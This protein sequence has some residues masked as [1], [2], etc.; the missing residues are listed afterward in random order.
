[1]ARSR[2]SYRS[3]LY[4]Q[5]WNNY[6]L[7]LIVGDRPYLEV[8]L[9]EMMERKNRYY[10]DSIVAITP[11]NLLSGALKLLQELR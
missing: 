3:H 6:P 10:M 9:Q 4:A 11:N 1:M 7:R 8:Q 5:V 2:S